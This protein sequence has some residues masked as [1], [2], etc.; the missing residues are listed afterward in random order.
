MAATGPVTLGFKPMASTSPIHLLNFRIVDCYSVDFNF[1]IVFGSL[2][3]KAILLLL[4]LLLLFWFNKD[5]V[6]YCLAFCLVYS[7]R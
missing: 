7:R 5:L 4:L 1:D 6:D 3:M 2:A